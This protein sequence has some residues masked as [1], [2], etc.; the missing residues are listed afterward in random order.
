MAIMFAMVSSSAEPATSVLAAD[1]GVGAPPAEAGAAAGASGG[2]GVAAGGGAGVAGVAAGRGRGR[3]RGRGLGRGLGFLLHDDDEGRLGDARVRQRGVVGQH[4]P[5]VHEDHRL[6]GLAL[7]LRNLRLDLRDLEPRLE[8]HLELGVRAGGIVGGQRESA[9]RETAKPEREG[10][11]ATIRGT[12][13]ASSGTNRSNP[14]GARKREEKD[15]AP[16]RRAAGWARDRGR[17]SRAS[18]SGTHSVLNAT[19]MVT[20]RVCR[21]WGDVTSPTARVLE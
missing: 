13:A 4:L 2:V 1:S 7:R 10:G 14:R 8:L 12:A 19:F 17:G 21:V 16:T 18:A 20:V 15:L 6:D 5:L 11:A 3:G 9:S